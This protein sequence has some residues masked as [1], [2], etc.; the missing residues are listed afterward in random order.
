[1]AVPTTQEIKTQILTTGSDKIKAQASS[2]T[3]TPVELAKYLKVVPQYIYNQMRA[4]RIAWRLNPETQNRV[5]ELDVAAEFIGKRIAREA[6]RKAK[7]EA[8]L[9]GE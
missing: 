2:G 1:M 4:G 6:E 3:V 9:R 8:E 5:I 7:I